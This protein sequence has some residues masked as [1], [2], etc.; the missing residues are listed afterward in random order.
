MAPFTGVIDR[1]ASASH[2]TSAAQCTAFVVE[3]NSRHNVSASSASP[4]NI[5]TV[6]R[7]SMIAGWLE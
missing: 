3:S 7:C 6:A 5:S 1:P 2:T 4:L